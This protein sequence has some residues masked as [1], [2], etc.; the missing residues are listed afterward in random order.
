MFLVVLV[1][2]LLSVFFAMEFFKAYKYVKKIQGNPTTEIRNLERGRFEIQGVVSEESEMIES[3]L[4]QRKCV[5]YFLMIKELSDKKWRERASVNTFKKCILDDGTGTCKVDLTHMEFDLNSK[6]LSHS[7]RFD[8]PTEQEQKILQRFGITPT[9]RNTGWNRT[10][11][12]EEYILRTGD[13]I[14]LVGHC[15]PQ[16]S[17]D[18]AHKMWGTSD[19]PLFLSDKSETELLKKHGSK[20]GFWGFLI[21][22][23]MSTAMYV[24]LFKIW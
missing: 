11:S 9:K 23:S 1:L 7:G 21:F 17:S 15:E 4:S 12:Y 19:T 8:D 16:P 10:F 13:S 18:Y 5:G 3:P 24:L 2:C 20:A 22:L 6:Y 14:Y